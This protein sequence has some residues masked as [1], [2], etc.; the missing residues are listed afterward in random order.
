[1]RPFMRSPEKS[2][3]FA[4]LMRDETACDFVGGTGGRS[5]S[6]SESGEVSEAGLDTDGNAFTSSDLGEPNIGPSKRRVHHSIASIIFATF[7]S[8]PVIRS[9]AISELIV[10]ISMDVSK[11]IKGVEGQ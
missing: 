8:S 4:G 6:Q 10:G 3:G 1:V 2:L 5:R 9:S 7:H 11:D